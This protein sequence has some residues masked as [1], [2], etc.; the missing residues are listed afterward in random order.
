MAWQLRLV[1]RGNTWDAETRPKIGDVWFAHYLTQDAD[2]RSLWDGIKSDE[3]T[4]DW[5]GKRPP[6]CIA[7]P[8]F[9]GSTVVW[10]PDQKPGWTV[11]G[12][13]PNLT[14]TPSINVEGVYHGFIQ[15]GMITDDLEGRKY[16]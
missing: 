6:I 12:E 1:E 5:E 14:V 2:H 7:L 8:G 11:T 4:R 15:N 10:I 3:F 13:A 16:D 9:K